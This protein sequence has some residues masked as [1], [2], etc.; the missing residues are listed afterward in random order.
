[1]KS[2]QTECN[3]E[4]ALMLGWKETSAHKRDQYGYYQCVEGYST[5]YRNTLD[6]QAVEYQYDKNAFA[7]EDLQFHSDWNW[8]MEAVEFIEKLNNYFIQIEEKSCYVYD[9]SKFDNIQTNAFI[10]KDADTKKEAVFTA[11]SDFAKLYNEGKL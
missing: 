8:L 1:M 10:I 2:E 11:V 6:E 5:P 9:T 4:I 3:K 7:V